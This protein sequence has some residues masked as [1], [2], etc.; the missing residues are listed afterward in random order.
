MGSNLRSEGVL[1][2][3]FLALFIAIFC[4]CRMHNKRKRQQRE[5]AEERHRVDASLRAAPSAEYGA[6][7]VE[8]ASAAP[9]P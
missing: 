5:Q 4:G 2:A 7:Y 3:A 9:P 6:V 8:G 1:G